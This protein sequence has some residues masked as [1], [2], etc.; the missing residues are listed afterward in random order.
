M[1][2]LMAVTAVVVGLTL[3]SERTSFSRDALARVT[4]ARLVEPWN[5]V[6]A[7]VNRWLGRGPLPVSPR[8]RRAASRMAA[9]FAE[10]YELDG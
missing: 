3:L 9:R 6:A 5:R 7:E 4:S 2:K 1:K 10:S 8:S